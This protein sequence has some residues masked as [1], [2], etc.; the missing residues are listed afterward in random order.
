MEHN[1]LKILIL[2]LLG[3]TGQ[4]SHQVRQLV[5]EKDSVDLS[6]RAIEMALLR[7]WRQGLLRRERNGRRFNYVITER[8]V[9]R[10]EWL[11]S[12]KSMAP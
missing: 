2:E 9:A 4:D 7:Y 11:T 3:P 8:G 12:Q 6:Q 5:K 1:R 10:R